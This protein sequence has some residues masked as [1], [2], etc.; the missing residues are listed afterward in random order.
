MFEV[1]FDDAKIFKDCIDALV[2][3]IDE[4]EFD[5]SKDGI[6]LRAMDPSQI[7]MVD[8]VLPK[9]AFEKYDVAKD[10]KI[11][12]NLDDL[13]KITSRSRPGDSLELKLDDSESR[14]ELVFKGKSRRKFNLPLLD[15]SAT[16]PK[17]PN[18]EFDARIKINGGMLKESLKDASLVSSHVILSANSKGFD[19]QAK[20]DKGDVTVESNKEDVLAEHAVT[21]D[22]KSMFALEY[23]NDL[24]KSTDSDAIVELDLKTDAPL[25]VHYSIGDAKITYFLAPRIE[26]A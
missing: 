8:F 17:V 25:R 20:G 11:G 4:G 18:I 16:S 14:L 9:S 15:I 3:L 12:L 24:L 19:I 7:A 1:K 2:T 21:K 26:S 22:S 23:L 13:S 10:T 5:V 6:K